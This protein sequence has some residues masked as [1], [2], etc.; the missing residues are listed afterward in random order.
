MTTHPDIAGE[1]G[2]PRSAA[3]ATNALWHPFAD[4]S[5]VA[6]REVVVVRGDGAWVEDANGK[7]YL[8]ASAAL[9]YCNVG[10]GRSELA[11]IAA[12]QMRELAAYQTFDVMTNRPALELAERI[13]DLAPLSDRAAVFF[14]SGGSDSVDTAA[15]I[16][17][18]FWTTV[19]EPQRQLI[20]CREGA[21]HGVN[22]FGTSLSG[23]EANASGW[24]PLVTQVVHDHPRHDL[25]ALERRARSVIEGKSPLSLASRFRGGRR[26]IRRNTDYWQRRS[27]SVPQGWRTR[28]SP[29]GRDR[30]RA[31]RPVVW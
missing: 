1:D 8:D 21:Y 31:T 23:I 20:I 6:D 7:R 11:D 30:L 12:A 29:R 14:T 26:A 2:T 18:R 15:K 25:A 5:S 22:A 17:R 19:G 3:R 16:A 24:G 28:R 9:W 27:R 13:R 10:H 4:M